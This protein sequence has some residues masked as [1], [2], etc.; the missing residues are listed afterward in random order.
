MGVPKLF[1]AIMLLGVFYLVYYV[2]QKRL[3]LLEV[4]LRDG[5]FLKNGKIE[6]DGKNLD[7]IFSSLNHKDIVE[8]GKSNAKIE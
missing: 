6:I 5:K 4:L 2:Q 7:G 1:L 8:K 3:K